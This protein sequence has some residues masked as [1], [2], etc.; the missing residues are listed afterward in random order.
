MRLPSAWRKASV[1]FGVLGF[2][3][4]IAVQSTE[5][6]DWYMLGL[7]C[8]SAL[9][10]A[11]IVI[12][13]G[14]RDGARRLLTDPFLI[15]V[16]A[17]S[18][19][20]LFGSLLLVIGPEDQASYVMAWYPTT[21]KDAVRVTAMNLIGLALSLFAAGV[22]DGSRIENAVKPAIA[23]FNKMS[24]PVIFWLFS[25]IGLGA[26]M[27]V[28]TTDNIISGIIRQLAELI[29]IAVLVGT[30]YRGRGEALLHTIAIMMAL[31]V[32]IMGLLSFN[33]SDTL[34][35]LLILLFGLYLRSPNIK[36]IA[37]LIISIITILSV[38][39]GPIIEAR[40][41]YLHSGDTSLSTRFAIL[42]EAFLKTADNSDIGFRG[43][44][45]SRLCYITPQVAAVNLYE[46]GQGGDDAELL[47]WVFVPRVFFPDKPIITRS[48]SDFNE[49]VTG[50]NKSS[51][52]IGLFISGYYNFGWIGLIV[53]SILSGWILS[54][55]SAISRSIVSSGSVVL[56]PMGLL[57][58]FMAFRIDGHF[59]SDYLGAFAMIMLPLLTLLLALRVGM[60]RTAS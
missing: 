25:G 32:S 52:G 19:Y 30:I 34:K 33:K 22:F 4:L 18:V 13:L 37:I 56:L 45:W 14:L 20:F 49:K 8:G 59:V 54:M 42:E 47:L 12:F 40:Y 53:A 17:F 3:A 38:L 6:D 51:T 1:V 48:G 5:P 60:S 24:M 29:L 35:P 55:F 10:Y 11:I 50:S 27:V 21:A 7:V 43:G 16:V 58:S 39:T 9:V 41:I 44:T 23:L 26:F 31:F 28:A 46:N 57:G 15:L 2:F 36:L